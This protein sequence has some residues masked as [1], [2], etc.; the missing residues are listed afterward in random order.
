MAQREEGRYDP[1][2][3]IHVILS[4]ALPVEAFH[5]DLCGLSPVPGP[6]GGVREDGEKS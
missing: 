2:S 6:D 1:F 5:P 3:T 4:D